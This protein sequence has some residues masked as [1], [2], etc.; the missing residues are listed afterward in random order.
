MNTLRG[1][2]EIYP[3]GSDFKAHILEI[4]KFATPRESSLQWAQNLRFLTPFEQ[5]NSDR[6]ADWSDDE[7]LIVG[8]PSLLASL[9][10][11][12]SKCPG[13]ASVLPRI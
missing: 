13:K 10:V 8:H 2:S 6:D 5:A 3:N 7:G 11:G 1:W 4:Q 12:E 9:T